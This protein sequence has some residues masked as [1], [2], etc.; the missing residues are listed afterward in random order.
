MCPPVW[1]LSNTFLQWK[2]FAIDYDARPA[3]VTL[4]DAGI[5]GWNR[6]WRTA[7]RP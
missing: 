7:T 2:R 1:W 4:R 3:F 6:M 5:D